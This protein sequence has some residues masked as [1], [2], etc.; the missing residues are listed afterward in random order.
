MSSRGNSSKRG[1]VA[2]IGLGAGGHAKVLIEALRLAGRYR[3]VGLLDARAEMQGQE[4]LG[5]RVLGGDSLL[6]QIT[7]A[8]HFLVSLAGVSGGGLRHR[9][10][11]SALQLG[12]KPVQVIHPQA[13]IS[14]S[15]CLGVGVQVLAGAIVNAEAVL[16]ANVILNTAAVVE[17]DCQIG[18]SVHIATGARLC[19]GVRVGNRA[20]IG[21]GAVIRQG[22]TIGEDAVVAAGAVVV[23]P[24]AA[25]TVVAGVPARPLPAKQTELSYV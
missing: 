13:L 7:E 3:V 25:G 16:G 22:S 1:L 5:V 17:H 11:E 9:L 14:K 6:E 19:G 4:V 18:D 21:A 2:V 10:Y 23:K 24:V 12:W 20:H 8:D 15:A